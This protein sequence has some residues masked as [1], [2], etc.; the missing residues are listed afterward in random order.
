MVTTLYE[1][2]GHVCLMFSDLVDDHDTLPVQTNQFLI[3][4]HGHGALID[5]GG[6]MTYNAL[7]L[8]MYRYFPPKQLDYVLA[9]HADPDIVASAGRWLTSSSCDI[10][11][12][13]VWERFLPHFC[14]VGKTEGRIVPIP[15]SGMAIPLGQ[16][17]LLAVPAHFLHSEG[18]FQFYDPVSRILF[19]GDLGASMVHANV[20]AKPVEDFDAHLPLMAP[21]HRRYMSGNRVCRLWAQMV[22]GLD[23]EW[24]VPQH[25]QAFRGKA[26]VNRFIDWVETLDCGIDLMTPDIFR[27]PALPNTPAGATLRTRV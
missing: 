10:L 12:S 3:V 24:I 20:A 18:N 14:T 19:S 5:P 7:F 23:I 15:D 21:F 13:R 6:Q 4:D 11:I 25:G 22:R 1:T 2:P 8:A 17:H 16:S 26:M 9:S 27:L